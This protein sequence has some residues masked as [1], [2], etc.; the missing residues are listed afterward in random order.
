MKQL[1]IQIL[2]MLVGSE[3]KIEVKKPNINFGEGFRRFVLVC[4]LIWVFCDIWSII[5]SEYRNNS[6]VFMALGG[7]ILAYICY[8]CLIKILCWIGAGFSG[9]KNKRTLLKEWQIKYKYWNRKCQ[10]SYKNCDEYNKTAI[11][12]ENCIVYNR[13]PF[14]PKGRMRRFD[15]IVY[16]FLINFIMKIVEYDMEIH[17]DKV[18]VCAFAVWGLLIV[19]DIFIVRNRIYDFTLSNKKAW[20]CSVLL[21]IFAL[22]L[23]SI[24]ATLIYVMIPI[25]FAIMAIPSKIA[26]DVGIKKTKEKSSFDIMKEMHKTDSEN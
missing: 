18:S 16:S 13:N 7:G 8:I 10:R 26:N 25:T 21:Q 2:S 4:I 5:T 17:V 22:I 9:K 14:I 23:V 20:S 24:N 11:Q 1:L 3:H 19:L 12:Q 15:Y 6:D